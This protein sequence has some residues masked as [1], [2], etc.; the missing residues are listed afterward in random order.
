MT[1][2]LQQR[3][4]AMAPSTQNERS[5]GELF[6]ELANETSMLVRQEMKLAATE[7]TQKATYAGKQA[8]FV[9]AGALLAVVSL[10]ALLAALILGLGTMI[11][12]WVSA[13]LVG[14]VVGVIAA[15]LV[16]KGATALR[17]VDV[18]PKQTIQTIKE[19]KSWVQQQVR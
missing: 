13:L 14:I 6:T 4:S 2:S 19:D 3:E 10:L 5:V 12:L 17:Q 16:W 7:M 11:A 15:V 1:P 18:V 8:A 9:G